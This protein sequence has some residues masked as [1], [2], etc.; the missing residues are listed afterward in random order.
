MILKEVFP[1]LG[2]SHPVSKEAPQP[3]SELYPRLNGFRLNYV[4]SP[5]VIETNSESSTNELDRI[6]L[7]F[8]RSQSDLIV[9]TGRTARSENLNSSSYAPIL[10]LTKT[11]VLLEIPAV[12]AQSKQSVYVTQR[13]GTIYPNSNAL[14]IGTFQ[15]SAQIFCAEFCRVNNFASVVLET[16]VSTAKDFSKARAITE[17]DLTVTRV[18]DLET[19]N[20][21][22]IDFLTELELENLTLLQLLNHDESWFFRFGVL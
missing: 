22:A 1:N 13:L 7:K 17:V 14:S 10:V 9:T 20:R 8:I 19:A 4:I 3:L 18:S 5:D 16:G 2:A 11:D 6:I 15:G 12:T 21:T